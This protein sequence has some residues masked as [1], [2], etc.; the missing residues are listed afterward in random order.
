MA[1]RKAKKKTVKGLLD[2]AKR[3]LFEIDKSNRLQAMGLLLQLEAVRFN[4]R[5]KKT[6]SDNIMKVVKSEYQEG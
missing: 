6:F 5:D 1:T 2:V 3:I 4:E